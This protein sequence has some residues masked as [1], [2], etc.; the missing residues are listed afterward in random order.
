V[1]FWQGGAL[2]DFVDT[3]T[4]KMVKKMGIPADWYIRGKYPNKISY[5][6]P[7]PPPEKKK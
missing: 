3:T 5:C 6:V 7:P 4:P 1:E 2:L